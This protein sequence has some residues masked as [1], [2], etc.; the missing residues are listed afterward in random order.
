M[1]F[2]LNTQE[3]NKLS[4]LKNSKILVTGGS[5]FFGSWILKFV[6]Y[7]NDNFSFNIKLYLLARRIT[8]NISEIVSQREDIIFLQQD[9]RNI[10]EVPLNIN[11]V[12]H[13]ACSPDNREHISNPVE[14]MDIIS[15][16]GK[17]LFEH[18]LNMPNLKRIINLSSGQIYGKV[19]KNYIS[20]NDIGAIEP[21]SIKS[22]YP[23]AKRFSETL[24]K[25]YESLYKLPIVQVRPFSFI[26]PFMSLEKPWAIN[27]FLHDA[28]K[29]KKI[30]IIGN[31]KPIRSYMYPTDMVEWLFNILVNA[32]NGCNYNLGSDEGVSLEELALTIKDKID[33][34]IEI[35]ILKMNE[36][37]N[38]FLPN[39]DFIKKEL[40]VSIKVGFNKAIEETIKWN[41]K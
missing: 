1:Y 13:A 4:D 14:V 35:Q 6:L 41:I 7:L 8:K 12:V 19:E 23:E 34:S 31:G 15:S 22:I 27:N 28:I 30:K 17:Q 32:Q 18:C 24:S 36:N 21:N 2:N 16:G 26:G 25:A 38:V 37:N 40:G 29:F 33:S 5:G 20:E 39:L 10:K 11:Y 3:L 9:I